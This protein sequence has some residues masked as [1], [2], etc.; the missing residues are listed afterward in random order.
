MTGQKT[1]LIPCTT[2]KLTTASSLT[3]TGAPVRARR[4][5]HGS[6]EAGSQDVGSEPRW[7][8]GM[9]RAGGL[10]EA[11]RITKSKAEAAVSPSELWRAGGYGV[12]VTTT[13]LTEKE[14]GDLHEGCRKVT[15][16][17]ASRRLIDSW[18]ESV[19]K[20]KLAIST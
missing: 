9:V 11:E 15:A 2:W 5:L 1:T 17:R 12:A 10:E 13:L 19:A 18:I 3:R 14:G 4:V 6:A 7:K 16:A 8:W 20:K